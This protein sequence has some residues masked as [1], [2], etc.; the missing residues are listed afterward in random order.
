MNKVK[1]GESSRTG[2]L[3][4]RVLVV[5]ESASGSAARASNVRGLW[6]TA[7][8]HG[9]WCNDVTLSSTT[10]DTTLILL[11]FAFGL[12]DSKKGILKCDS[13]NFLRYRSNLRAEIW[14]E[15]GPAQGTQS[16]ANHQGF[17]SRWS[18]ESS[19]FCT[20]I[21]THS[22]YWMIYINIK[23]R[24]CSLKKKQHVSRLTDVLQVCL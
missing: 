1:L 22:K 7:R 2:T 9:T 23:I 21:H 14:C 17:K 13:P 18:D 10:K 5:G 20:H 15:W 6:P 4:K 16:A 3:H 11:I 19:C 12:F 24:R 8:P